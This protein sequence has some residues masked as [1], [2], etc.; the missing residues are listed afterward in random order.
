MPQ[1]YYTQISLEERI[2]ILELESKESQL[3]LYYQK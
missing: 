3:T 1:H 2:I